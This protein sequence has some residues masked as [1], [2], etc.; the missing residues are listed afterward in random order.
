MRKENIGKLI[1]SKK[2]DYPAIIIG[3]IS[4]EKYKCILLHNNVTFTDRIDGLYYNFAT[5]NDIIDIYEK[6]G[7]HKL[8]KKHKEKR[9]TEDRIKMYTLT[10]TDISIGQQALQANHA[11][12]Q[13]TIEHNPHLYGEWNNGSII[14]LGLGSEKSLRKWIRKLENL[15]IK[16]SIFREPDMNNEITSIGILH[17]GDIFKGIPLL[18]D[19][20]NKN[21]NETMLFQ[22]AEKLGYSL[23]KEAA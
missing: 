1:I 19:E 3:I 5:T 18:L 10:R 14:N 15:N 9:L 2:K 20:K 21:N 7:D 17:Q 22:M 12:T 13:Y 11:A 23:R 4:K 6:Y 8:I 16:Y